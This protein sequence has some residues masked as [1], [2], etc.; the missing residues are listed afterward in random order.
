MGKSEIAILCM[1][2]LGGIGLMLLIL[3]LS[4]FFAQKKKVARCTGSVIGNVVK[5]CFHGDGRMFP[6]V[7]YQVEGQIYT[8]K[9][10]YRGIITKTRVSP[11]KIYED[12][13]AYVTE[14]DYLFVPLSAITNLKAM[15]QDIWPIG[16][17]MLVYY[18]PLCPKQAYAERIPANPSLK[19]VVFICTGIG[20]ILVSA[21][22]AFLM[23]L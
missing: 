4:F 13:G 15:A 1:I 7:E 16:N 20:V 10:Q 18:N 2:I 14:K 22:A 19:A 23:M 17:E 6:V 21:I 5:H 3:G 11:Q 8:V 12:K 9:R